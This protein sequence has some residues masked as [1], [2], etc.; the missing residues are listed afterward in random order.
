MSHNHNDTQ[1][2]KIN[3]DV[4]LTLIESQIIDEYKKLNAKCDIILSKINNRKT[5]NQSS[6]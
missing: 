4:D 6:L 1:L 5:L 2:K 3:N